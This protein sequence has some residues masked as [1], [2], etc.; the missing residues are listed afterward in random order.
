MPEGGWVVDVEKQNKLGKP[1]A[2]DVTAKLFNRQARK[3]KPG[4]QKQPAKKQKHQQQVAARSAMDP[5]PLAEAPH[6][7][8]PLAT[9]A[10]GLQFILCPDT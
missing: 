9:Q 7:R 1:G 6:G 10:L 5:L 8:P 4:N 3:A 2:E